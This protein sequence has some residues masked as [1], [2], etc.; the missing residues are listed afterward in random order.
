VGPGVANRPT[1]T[2]RAGSAFHRAVG[3]AWAASSVREALLAQR[4]RGPSR[5]LLLFA[6]GGRG[7]VG[8]GATSDPARRAVV[9]TLT[10]A[11]TDT[12]WVPSGGDGL[13]CLYSA[14]SAESLDR[15]ATR[16]T[17]PA[18]RAPRPPR[19]APGT[20]RRRALRAGA[21]RS[22]ERSRRWRCDAGEGGSDPARWCG[23]SIGHHVRDEPTA[24]IAAA[25][26]TAAAPIQQ[27]RARGVPGRAG[28]RRRGAAFASSS[29]ATR[30]VFQRWPGDHVVAP[31]TLLR[32]RKLLA[33]SST[34]LGPA[35]FRLRG[36]DRPRRVNARRA[37][38]EADL[39]ARRHRTRCARDRPS[40]R[41]E[42][43]APRR[44]LVVDNT[45]MTAVLQRPLAAGATCVVYA[46][47]KYLG[48]ATVT[49]WCG[50]WERR[51]R[52]EPY[53]NRI[54][55]IQ[56]A[57]VPSVALRLAGWCGRGIRTLRGGC[58]RTSESALKVRVL[59]RIRAWKP[60]TI[61]GCPGIP[62]YAWRMRQMTGSAACCPLQGA[63]RTQRR[64]A[65][66]GKVRVFT[67]ATSFG[68]TESLLEH[69]PRWRVR[70]RARRRTP[71][72]RIGLEHNRRL[73][74][75]SGSPG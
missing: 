17:S 63:R 36:H 61:P 68:S 35:V 15:G 28:G 8:P 74:G 69:R 10:S 31:P 16:S 30:R 23:R 64:F 58:A 57:A 75:I 48:P 47:T 43:A 19:C 73:V 66:A 1:N 54:R 42:L 26:S 46:T 65:V 56:T 59:A 55:T 6:L 38:D 53:F 22:D 41:C 25:S 45:S 62:Q 7:G 60:C 72:A 37:G 9:G 11:A 24:T 67:C 5:R 70:R 52:D 71:A 44:A 50:A 4:A 34:R 49:S 13:C 18:R 14:R 3:Q 39:V 27:E 40:P 12:P 2:A 20:T 32:H 21:R 29:A 51:G 33:T